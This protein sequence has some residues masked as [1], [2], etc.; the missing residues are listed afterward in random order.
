V[1]CIVGVV[2]GDRVFMGGDSAGVCSNSYSLVVRA[3]Q[4]VFRNGLF[5]FGFCGSFRMGQL[6]R[7]SFEPPKH[8]RRMDVYRYM[9]TLFIDE[10]RK[11][12][13][14]GGF[15]KKEHDVEEIDGAFLVAYRGRLFEID[16]DY[17]V[18]E[19]V[20]G[21]GATGCGAAIAQG[22]L[23][24]SQGVEPKKRVRAALEAAER[25]SGG[26]RRPFYV[27]ASGE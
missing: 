4:K 15:A 6:L 1:T 17:Q 8:P 21:F 7:Y 18:G 9:V 26:V 16:S 25:Y 2:E 12:L 27:M 19:A 14:A 13:K 3:D 11:V 20:D 22:A 10:V 24:V 23:Y 5:V